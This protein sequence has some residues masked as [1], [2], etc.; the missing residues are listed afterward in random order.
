MLSSIDSWYFLGPLKHFNA[1]KKHLWPKK[2][3][4]HLDYNWNSSSEAAHGW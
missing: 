1:D 4:K 3:K 2:P